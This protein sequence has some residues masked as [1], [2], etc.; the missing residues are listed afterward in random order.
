MAIV[1]YSVVQPKPHPLL[2]TRPTN[3][4][5]PR[6]EPRPSGRARWELIVSEAIDTYYAPFL[7][8]IA[9]DVKL[10]RKAVLLPSTTY[11]LHTL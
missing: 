9:G 7:V 6:F 4:T 1:S 3:A 11:T 8:S 2:D 5:S 10:W